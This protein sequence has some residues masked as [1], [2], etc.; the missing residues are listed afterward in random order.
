[1]KTPI[2]LAKVTLEITPIDNRW[3]ATIEYPGSTLRVSKSFDT[4]YEAIQYGNKLL[5]E[6]RKQ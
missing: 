3:A 1:M 5:S 4:E 6:Y 2:V